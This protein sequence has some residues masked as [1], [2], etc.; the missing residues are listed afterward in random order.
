MSIMFL[1]S[2]ALSFSDL[3]YGILI[4]FYGYNFLSYLSNAI[5]YSL[6]FGFFVCLVFS[7]S[8]FCFQYYFLKVPLL[9]FCILVCLSHWRLSPNTY[10]LN[11]WN[12]KSQQKALHMWLLNWE[13]STTQWL[14]ENTAFSLKTS[15][16][17]YKVFSLDSREDS[18]NHLSGG[19]GM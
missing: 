19:T 13:I 9:Y 17:Q 12:T 6:F 15:K 10:L 18:Y 16:C 7:Q 8:Y 3:F 11:K 4:L 2:R 1:I 5:T 14:G